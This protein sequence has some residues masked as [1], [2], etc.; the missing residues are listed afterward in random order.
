MKIIGIS[1]SLRRASCN[2]GLLRA[3]QALLLADGHSLEILDIVAVPFYNAD[4]IEK[5]APVVAILEKMATADA[6]V[7]ACPEYNYSISPALKNV[8]DW[9]SREPDNRIFDGKA[10]A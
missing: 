7:F 6:F 4:L 5:P 9:A 10:L 8:L 2:T 1:G 3:A